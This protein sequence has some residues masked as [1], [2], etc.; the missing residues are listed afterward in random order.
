M[1]LIPLFRGISFISLRVKLLVEHKHSQTYTLGL[2]LSLYLAQGLPAGF[3]TQALP[4][5]LRQYHVSLQLIGWSGLLLFPSAVK[6]IWAPLVDHHYSE[7]VGQSRSWILPSSALA[8]VIL[9]CVAMFEP[10]SLVQL[11]PA[12]VLFSLLFVLSIIG[13]TQDIA[14]DG[15]AVRMLGTKA[16][17]AG[18][19]IQVTGYRIGL[20]IGGGVLLIVMDYWSWSAVFFA[21][22]G[23]IVLNTLPILFFKEP[24]WLE[25]KDKNSNLKSIQSSMQSSMQNQEIS[26]HQLES[27][28]IQFIKRVKLQFGYFWSNTEMRAWLLVLLVFKIADY[29]SSG[30]VKP[31]MVDMGFSLAKI[32]FWGTIL[33]S[34]S[35]LVGAGLAAWW[36][37]YMRRVT[38]LIL[39][40]G[41]QAL[42]TGLYALIAWLYAHHF[43]LEGWELYAANAI[44]H[45][46]AA[47]AMVGLLTVAMDYSR[48]QHA[49]SDF[50]FQVCAFTVLGG[51]GYLASGYLASS[52]GYA[53]QFGLSAVLGLILLIPI[54]R[55]GRYFK[56]THAVL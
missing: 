47:M 33:G 53:G 28:F 27:R 20:I 23:L 3:I 38:A 37:R 5:I 14:T 49:G 51:M 34:L 13:A 18:N 10:T 41:L 26:L 55:W 6:F 45:V 16:R 42:T 54:L 39:F 2:L 15:L 9:L 31:M 44:E 43:A 21:M 7:K 50:T 40:N 22:I 32:G 25:K 12:I 48:P 52:L 35:S 30:M 46:A 29:M 4:A 11:K 8:I 17:S 56:Q 36:M 1:L 24:I 19:A